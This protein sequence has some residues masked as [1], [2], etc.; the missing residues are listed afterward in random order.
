MADKGVIIKEICDTLDKMLRKTEGADPAELDLPAWWTP[1][2][3]TPLCKWGLR[4]QW[5]V[6]ATGMDKRDDMQRYAARHGGTIGGEWLYDFTCLEYSDSECLK[7]I[8]LVAECEW[9]NEDHIN[10]DFEKLL[11]ARA[12]VRVMIFNGNHYKV[13][14]SIPSHG[15]RGFRKHIRKCKHTRAG[16][17]YLFAAR[18]HESSDGVSVNHRFDY[19][20]FVA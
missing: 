13:R 8:P 2:V 19:Q 3:M 20:I 11:L 18:L 4:K 15:L 5:W 6:G 14:E 17:T 9:G 10:E 16:D 12:D 1:R 7:G